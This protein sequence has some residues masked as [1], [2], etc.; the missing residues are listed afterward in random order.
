MRHLDTIVISSPNPKIRNPGPDGRL[1]R[2]S[3]RKPE[4]PINSCFLRLKYRLACHIIADL[5]YLSIFSSAF[6]APHPQAFPSTYLA[7]A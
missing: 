1:V 5:A 4:T 6:S 3:P 7:S 2:P